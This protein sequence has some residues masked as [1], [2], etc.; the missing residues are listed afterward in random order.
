MV[1]AAQ[2]D[3]QFQGAPFGRDQ[4]RTGLSEEMADKGG[5]KAAGE[6]QWAL[7]FF[8]ARKITGRWI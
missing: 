5:G 4:A 3:A 7:G 8:M 1:E 2:A 6:L